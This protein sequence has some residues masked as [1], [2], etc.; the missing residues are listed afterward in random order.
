MANAAVIRAF[1][2]NSN[3]PAAG[4]KCKNKKAKMLNPPVTDGIF[5]GCLDRLG[6]TS[7]IGHLAKAL[8]IFDHLPNLWKGFIMKAIAVVLGVVLL[9]SVVLAAVET[10]E[11][12]TKGVGQSRDEAIRSGLYQAVGQA[13]G[14]RIASGEYGFDFE[15]SAAGIDHRRRGHEVTFDSVSVEATGTLARTEFEGLV[16]RYEVADEQQLENGDYAVNLR[17]WIYDYA[18]QKSERVS[19]AVMPLKVS[20]QLYNFGTLTVIGKDVADKLAQRLSVV[21]SESNKFS[22]LDREYTAE[23][24]KEQNLLAADASLEEQAKIGESLGAA[25]LLVGTISRAEVRIKRSQS[26][27]IGHELQEYEADYVFDYR[28]IAAATREVKLSDTVNISLE[29]DGVRRLVKKWGDENTDYRE[30]MDNLTAM[31]A[32]KAVGYVIDTLY[33]V[34]VAKITDNGLVIINQGGR[35]IVEGA[36][37]EVLR[38]SEDIIDSDTNESLGHIEEAAGTVKIVKAG[39]KISYGRLTSGNIGDIEDGMVAR[40]MEIKDEPPQGRQSPVETT[41]QGGIKMPFDK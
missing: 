16:A 5:C 23:Y 22:M 27:A 17:V 35:R 13:S 12:G 30:M 19:L 20:Q 26:A 14:V 3:R 6:M 32:D 31:A 4:L 21:L 11:V 9:S 2:G 10:V 24:L 33:P 28:V 34:R 8:H 29:N 41:P 25:L 15:S 36:V 38:Q 18:A 7:R 39:P 40:Q 1:R 37:F